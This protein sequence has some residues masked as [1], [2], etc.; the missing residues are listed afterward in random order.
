MMRAMLVKSACTGVQAVESLKNKDAEAVVRLNSVCSL[1][2]ALTPVRG[3]GE[4]VGEGV[5][6]G[7]AETRA[8]GAAQ[9]APA[10]NTSSA[11]VPIT[12]FGHD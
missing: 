3:M 9:G 11:P 10:T 5:T 12:I 6:L 1:Q 8:I 4:G 2:G 7:E